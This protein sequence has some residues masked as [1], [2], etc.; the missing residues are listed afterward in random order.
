MLESLESLPIMYTITD[1]YTDITPAGTSRARDLININPNF[2]QVLLVNSSCGKESAST[3]IIL[4]HE[5]GRRAQ[6]IDAT[7][8]CSLA[9]GVLNPKVSLGR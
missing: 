8:A 9:A 3:A 6:W 7:L 2:H 4:A 1:I 5:L